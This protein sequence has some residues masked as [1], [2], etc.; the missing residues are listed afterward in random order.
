MAFEIR[1]ITQVGI[2]HRCVC[3]WTTA[4]G[5]SQATA[6]LAQGCR[7]WGNRGGKTSITATLAITVHASRGNKKQGGRKEKKNH[8]AVYPER[9]GPRRPPAR[10][11][12]VTACAYL[13][14]RPSQNG[15]T[16]PWAPDSADDGKRK[17][18]GKK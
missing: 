7:G 1:K 14:G 6:Q 4:R 18:K 2:V 17:K 5:L 9:S 11:P 13:S 3:T 8:L 15:V 12:S 10:R 16:A